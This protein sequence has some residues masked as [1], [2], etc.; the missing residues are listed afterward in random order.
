M[1]DAEGQAR[2]LTLRR[3]RGREHIAVGDGERMAEIIPRWEWRTFGSSFGAAEGHFAAMEPTGVQESDELYLVSNTNANVKVRFDLMDVKVLVETDADGLEQWR[4]I[5]KAQ[6]PV[7]QPEVAR[8]F[9]ALGEQPPPLARDTYTLDQF[10]A[11]LAPSAGLRPVNV[12]KRRVRYKVGGCTSEVSDVVADG[13]ATRTIAI[14][15]EDAAAVVAAV[16]SVELWNYV[17]TSYGKGLTA[18]V[19]HHPDRYAVIDVGTNSVKFHVGERAPDGGWKRVVDRAE[20]SRLGEG[21]DEHGSIQPEPL[22]RTAQAVAGMVDEARRDGAMAITAVGTA[23]FRIAENSADAIAAI[24]ERA[25]L[26]VEVLSG[27]EESR[28]A[29]LAAK[30]AAPPNATVVV[31][32]D[33]GGGSSQFTFGRS[34][35]IVDRFSVNVGAVSYTERFGLDQ[36]ISPEKLAEALA[37]IKSDLSELSRGPR[38]DAVVGMGGAVTN[39]TAVSKQMAKYDPDAIQGSVLTKAEIERQIEMY[40]SMS[41]DERR[42]V[43]G[44][45]PKR[46]EVI[47]AG[48]CI[49][50]TILDEM[51]ADSFTVSDRGLRHGVLLERFAKEK[52]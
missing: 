27:E 40:R 16:K 46:A 31:V 36:A 12:H 32:F 10:S 21:L 35:Q 39:M 45:Q 5:M 43:V 8:I 22:K 38:A 20:M 6:F 18:A 26:E 37:A 2:C 7:P 30:S 50:R 11:E 25:G 34:D 4:P 9:D 48:A 24:K 28:V 3:T 42:G 51:G 19:D 13:V 33:T 41:A 15:S 23:V 29:Y 17:N 14:E 47:L 49:V 44:L 52:Q 1:D